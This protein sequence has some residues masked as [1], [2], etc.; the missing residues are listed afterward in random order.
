MEI[1]NVKLEDYWCGWRSLP[2]FVEIDRSPAHQEG[3]VI[4]AR[5]DLNGEYVAVQGVGS[6][7]TIITGR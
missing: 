7:M 6:I 4:H 2:G 5:D 1:Q 3:N